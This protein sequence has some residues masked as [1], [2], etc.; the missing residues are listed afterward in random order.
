[1]YIDGVVG[2]F[3]T[4]LKFKICVCVLLILVKS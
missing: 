1:M 4:Y 2:Y 3:K